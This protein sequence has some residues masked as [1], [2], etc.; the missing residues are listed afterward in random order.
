[1]IASSHTGSAQSNPAFALH[2]T[3]HRLTDIEGRLSNQLDR[4]LG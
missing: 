4:D 3:F 2:D 1:V